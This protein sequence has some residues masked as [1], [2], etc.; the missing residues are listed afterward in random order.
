VVTDERRAESRDLYVP[1]PNGSMAHRSYG[2]PDGQWVL[3]AEMNDRGVW[4]PCRLIPSDGSSSGRWAGPRDAAC[5]SAAWSPDGHWMYLSSAA[6]GA[7]HIWR[8]RLVASGA[9]PPPE[10]ITSG[11]NEEEGIAMAPDGRSFVTAVGLR[12]SAVWLHDTHGERQISLEGYAYKPSFT[13]DGRHLLYL[14]SKGAPAETSE[15]WMASLDSGRNE[16]LLSDLPVVARIGFPLRYDVSP[17]GRQVAVELRDQKGKH[18]VWLARVDGQSAP[19]QV[20]D[21]E[22]DNPKFVANGRILFRVREG[23]YGFA[24][25]VNDDG[26]G[27]RKLIEHPVIGIT[28]VSPDGR[29]VVAYLRPTENETGTTVAVPL[30][31]GPPVR[32]YGGNIPITW[33][34]DGKYFSM[35][36]ASS[37]RTYVIPLPPG[38]GLPDISVEGFASEADIAALPGVEIIDHV[39]VALGPTPEVYA[40]SR[41]TTQRNLYRIPT[42]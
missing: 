15:L 4:L 19:R 26:T 34:R 9:L 31:G 30:D 27:L 14:V 35:P 42:P 25:A 24:Y 12:Q 5:R 1:L 18:H 2:S 36:I 3:A 11:P 6:G 32:I 21:L 41:E 29:W 39:D 10:Q 13:P 8:Q 33:S 28:A 37:G 17:D 40:F 22:G 38:W 23:P 16:P 20:L 7:Y